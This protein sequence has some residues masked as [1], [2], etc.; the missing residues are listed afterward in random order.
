MKIWIHSTILATSLA[1]TVAVGLASAAIYE[2]GQV[3]PKGDRLVLA[4]PRPCAGNFVTTEARGDHLSV[5]ASLP[6]RF[7]SN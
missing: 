2:M 3:A 7:C 6:D 5:L 1:T 4:A